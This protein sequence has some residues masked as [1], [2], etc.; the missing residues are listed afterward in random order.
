MERYPAAVHKS[1]CT[2]NDTGEESKGFSAF[3]LLPG[4]GG[5]PG[6]AARPPRPLTGRHP[7]APPG[8][9]GAGRPPS[10]LPAR[11]PRAAEAAR[12]APP[13]PWLLLRSE[14][15]RMLPAVPPPG[16][17]RDRHGVRGCGGREGGTERGRRR[18]SWGRSLAAAS[19][20]GT[21]GCR[22]PPWAREA[23]AAP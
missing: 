16:A 13:N 3:P 4:A 9:A 20:Q 21:S 8:A 12:A 11:I 15:D 10:P 14:R 19:G 5:S 17:G 2:G 6:A 23:L 22:L 18:R 1:G 7:P